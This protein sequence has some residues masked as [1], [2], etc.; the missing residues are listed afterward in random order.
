MDQKHLGAKCVKKGDKR[1]DLY[2]ARIGICPI[3][4]CEFRAV[5]DFKERKQKYCSKKCWSIRGDRHRK[6]CIGCGKLGLNKY[7]KTHCSREC[8]LKQTGE[9][10]NGWRGE[11]AGYSARHKI[12]GKADKCFNC[13]GTK[14][15]VE[16]AN[17]S[18]KYL[19]D[20]MDYIPLCCSCH[21]YFDRGKTF[22]RPNLIARW[23]K[24][25]GQK[26]VLLNEI[27]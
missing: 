5:K 26:A 27:S 13:N 14:P 21:R 24:Y 9:M 3:C 12:L 25:T 4:S 10:A 22:D 23:E 11:S 17:I 8:S 19:R 18:G 15:R 1:P 6:V 7:G 16:W 2:R 20:K